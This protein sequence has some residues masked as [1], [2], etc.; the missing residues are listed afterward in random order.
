MVDI[1][2]AIRHGATLI[3]ASH[4]VRCDAR[5]L[6]DILFPPM[7]A[8]SVSVM[9]LTPSLFMR[10]T[11]AEIE[12]RIFSQLSKLRVLAFGGEPFPAAST[13]HKW[14]NSEPRHSMR[15]F[16]LY[17]L[18]EMSCWAGIH[19]ITADDIRCNRKVP[20]GQPMDPYTKFEMNADGE[21]LLRSTVRKC[22]QP[23]LSDD[24]VCSTDFEFVL[25]TGDLVEF[26]DGSYS[27]QSRVNSVIKFYGKKIDLA[28]IEWRAKDVKNVED[29][30]C[31]FNEDRNL[32]ML[33]VKVDGNF[34]NIKKEIVEAL[35]T[36]QVRVKIISVLKFPL[37]KH[38]KI[39]KNDL[40]N[41]A[42]DTDANDEPS[43]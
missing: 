3:M 5:K 26:N 7:N 9:Q 6:L 43:R 39:C 11:S 40:L 41:T 34:E 35:Q 8:S 38:G 24:E 37:T 19:E 20:I 42:H 30:V 36:I 15:I 25:H 17:G 12:Q 13:L 27:F 16:N 18:T 33:F 22:Y 10:W 21:L 32:I 1:C 28:E 23:Q 29:A 4:S 14:T 31:L 2:L